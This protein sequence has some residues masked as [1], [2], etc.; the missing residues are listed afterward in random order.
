M[1]VCCGNHYLFEEKLFSRIHCKEKITKILNKY[2]QKSNCAATVP[3]STF[4]CLWAIYICIST[5]DLPILLQEICG[6]IL[7][8]YIY[9]LKTHE[10]GNWDRGH[11]IPRN[12]IQKWDFHCSEIELR[13]LLGQMWKKQISDLNL[14]LTVCGGRRRSVAR[15]G[16]GRSGCSVARGALHLLLHALLLPRHVHQLRLRRH[17]K[18]LAKPNH[19]KCDDVTTICERICFYKKR[20]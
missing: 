9:R 6:L 4:M 11:A 19:I 8:I 3:I 5:I 20:F 14:L 15:T 10:C 13:G 17:L 12:G 18:K 2:S 16:G 1:H 7:E